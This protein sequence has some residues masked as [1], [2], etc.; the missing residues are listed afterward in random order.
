MAINDLGIP[1]V[2]RTVH[3]PNGAGIRSGRAAMAGPGP[4]QVTRVDVAGAGSVEG[5]M[6]YS[7]A[8]GHDGS[9][10]TSGYAEVESAGP[11]AHGAD[12]FVADAEGRFGTV[13]FV[14][15]GSAAG[16]VARAGL[17]AGK[18][19]SVTTGTGQRLAIDLEGRGT[20]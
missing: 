3:D 6:H 1:Q 5:V 8:H 12:V 16:T 17:F 20:K 2:T 4:N 14:P 19:R 11:V 15:P 13:A 18:A 7:R 10:Q 9:V